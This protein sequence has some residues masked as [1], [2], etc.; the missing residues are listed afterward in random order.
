MLDRIDEILSAG[1]DDLEG[2]AIE[3][4]RSRRA[5]AQQLEAGLSFTR[6][7]VQGRLDIVGAE[8]SR[9]ASGGSTTDLHDLVER[10]PEILADRVHAP[11]FGRLPQV[12]APAD[13]ESLASEVDQIAPVELLTSIGDLDADALDALTDRLSQFEQ[14]VSARRRRMH[15]VIDALQG[16]LT[17]RYK[18][19][20]ASVETLLK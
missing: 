9:R 6:R 15:D 14:D 12:L 10:L 4:I 13:M 11:G 20:E 2:V 7:I 1:T 17:R 3:D 18:T 5:E 16:E 8:I 19:G